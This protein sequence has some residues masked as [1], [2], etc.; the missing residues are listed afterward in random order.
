MPRTQNLVKSNRILLSLAAGFGCL[1]SYGADLKAPLESLPAETV[2]AFRIDNRPE[3]VAQYVEK[4]KLGKLLFSDEKIAQYK[5]FANELLESDEES[6]SF[7]EKLGEVGLTTDDLFAMLNSDF[8]AAVALQEV[9]GFAPMPTL[10]FW[11]GMEQ[12]LCDRVFGAVLKASGENEELERVDQELAGVNA[13]RIRNK[14]Q[15]DSFLIAQLENRFLFAIGMPLDMTGVTADNAVVFEDAEWEALGMFIEAQRGAAGGFLSEFYGD[16]GINAVRPRFDSRMEVLADI[17]KLLEFVPAESAQMIDMLELGQFTKLGLWSG[18]VGME[19]RSVVFL[20]APAP[21][22]GFATLIENESFDFSPPEWVPANVNSYSVVSFDLLKLYDV[23]VEIA[24][25]LS[26]PVMVDQQIA[27]ANE[28]LQQ[29]LQTDIATLMGSFGK[30][31]HMVDYPIEVSTVNFMGQ[32]SEVP[33]A[34]QAVVVDFSRPDILQAAMGMAPMIASDPNGPVKIIEE[35]GFSGLRFQSPQGDVTVAFGSGKLVFA[36]GSEGVSSR[37]FSALNNPP[38]G[39]DAL[40]ND[41]GLREFVGRVGPKA[42]TGFS[43]AQG[44]NMLSNL[45]P[46]FKML[47]E[48]LS[49]KSPEDAARVEDFSALLPTAEE[50]KGVLGVVFS[51]FETNQHGLLIEGLNEYK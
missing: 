14:E 27:G 29:M 4:T 1:V 40:V 44:D 24:K 37:I 7:V 45:V 2:A 50:L 51:R 13:S 12:A 20:G 9:D 35:Q 41:S 17:S 19:E 49:T 25:R 34:P 28:G 15:G 43:F 18:L 16:A 31:F 21:R 39:T 30:R 42:G 26:D 32:S 3:V 22:S 33:R 6:A 46:V 38:S 36:V 48:S 8:G 5:A 10:Y 23:G 47:G 11:A